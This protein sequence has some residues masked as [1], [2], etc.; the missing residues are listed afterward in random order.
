MSECFALGVA[1]VGAIAC[2]RCLWSTV[3][4]LLLFLRRPPLPPSPSS[5]CVFFLGHGKRCTSGLLQGKRMGTSRAPR[6]C[7]T[8]H[9]RQ[10]H[11][12][13]CDCNLSESNEGV[14]IMK[15]SIQINEVTHNADCANAVYGH[16]LY[17][18]GITLIEFDFKPAQRLGSNTVVAASLVKCVR[19]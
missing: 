14:L 11:Q 3:F 7:L 12:W 13:T 8:I 5:S 15:I 9:S 1:A 16:T 2:C 18:A 17:R 4:T 6:K 19:S 10:K